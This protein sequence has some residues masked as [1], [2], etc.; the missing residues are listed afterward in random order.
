MSSMDKRKGSMVG[1][2]KHK[3]TVCLVMRTPIAGGE[4]TVD[5]IFSNPFKAD[6]YIDEMVSASDGFRYSMERF[7]VE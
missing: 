4:S 5:R 1:P 3:R 7:S 2:S 6:S